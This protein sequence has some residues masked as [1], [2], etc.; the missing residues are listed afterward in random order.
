MVEVE[1]LRQGNFFK[2][3]VTSLG[4]ILGDGFCEKQLKMNDIQNQ[5]WIDF[6]RRLGVHWRKLLVWWQS[7]PERQSC[8]FYRQVS[9]GSG[10]RRSDWRVWLLACR[11]LCEISSWDFAKEREEMWLWHHI[12][13]EWVKF[14]CNEKKNEL[15]F[16][17][18]WEL[19]A[20]ELV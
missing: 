9:A 16:P 8:L 7:Y 19:R 18:F 4:F 2:R 14:N 1:R 6:L 12:D 3:W 10:Y 11:S 15:Q 5:S 17:L 20:E 13:N